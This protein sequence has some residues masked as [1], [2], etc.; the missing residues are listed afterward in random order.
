LN[1]SEAAPSP[2]GLSD[3]A[4]EPNGLENETGA[5][6][7]VP[8]EPASSGDD[9]AK[10][11]T[12]K[13]VQKRLDSLTSDKRELQRINERLLALLERGGVSERQAERQVEANAEPVR[14]DYANH[15]DYLA[16]RADHK[17][18]VA[19]EQALA[20]RA[21]AE[22]REKAVQSAKEADATWTE[23]VDKAKAKYDDFED[24]AYALPKDG[25]PAVTQ[26]MAEAIKTSEIGPEIA[27]Y[28]GS[29]VAE[30]KRIAAMTPAAQAREIGKLEAKLAEPTKSPVK[31]SSAP[32]PIEPVSGKSSPRGELRGNE[33]MDEIYRS[34][35]PN[36][37]GGRQGF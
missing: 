11:K 18:A 36:R 15:E 17:V 34:M 1:E 10:G 8:E 19:V 37:K 2:E 25:G 16:A 13:G 7:E 26:H 9:P 14:G 3:P 20:K 32:D 23:A 4:S 22:K 30:S 24:V 28:L 27:Y 31:V 5:S 29:N 33:S 12:A 35:F 6:P 21:E